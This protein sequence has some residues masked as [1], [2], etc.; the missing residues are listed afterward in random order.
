VPPAVETLPSW[1]S[2]RDDRCTPTQVI[3]EEGF[4]FFELW[5]LVFLQ[6]I[7]P[8]PFQMFLDQGVL[9]QGF[10]GRALSC[11]TRLVTMDLEER[12]FSFPAPLPF[13]SFK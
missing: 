1:V 3:G 7:A 11:V 10:C 9:V 13:L 12:F 4:F 6:W 5:R 8:R 2:P